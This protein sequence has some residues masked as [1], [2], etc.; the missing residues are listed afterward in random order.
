MSKALK[1]YS[2][3]GRLELVVS[4]DVKAE[5]LVDALLSAGKLTEHDF[6]KILGEYFDGGL[7]IVG[8]SDNDGYG[9]EKDK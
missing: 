9:L 5:N 8:V 4:I 3:T 7:A 6:V 2:V 1:T